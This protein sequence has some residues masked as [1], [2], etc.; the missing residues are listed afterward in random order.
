MKWEQKAEEER[1]LITIFILLSAGADGEKREKVFL[2]RQGMDVVGGRKSEK[3]AF[4]DEI[5]QILPFWEVYLP[6]SPGACNFLSSW[7]WK[8]SIPTPVPELSN[9]S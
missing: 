9:V 3:W 5:G 8:K 6:S 7:K 2:V 1:R 4:L